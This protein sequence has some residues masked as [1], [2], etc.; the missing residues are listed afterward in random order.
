TAAHCTEGLVASRLY[1]I[2]AF[3]SFSSDATWD[4]IVGVAQK[5]EH[6]NY[7]QPVFAN[8][9]ISILTL[10]KSASSA[11]ARVFGG[12]D[13][14]AGKTSTVIGVGL[15]SGGG[16][17]PNILQ[18][19]NLQIVSNSVCANAWGSSSITPSML[20][21]GGTS[22][23][24]I[25]ACSGDSGGPLFVNHD[26]ERVQAGIVSWGHKDCAQPGFYDVYARTGAL[27]SFVRQHAPGA[28]I[29]V[30]LNFNIV[31]SLVPLLFDTD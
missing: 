30:D 22:S 3:H 20:C 5:A 21:A 26:G 17:T 18:K 31:P 4:K 8:N 25:G 16:T 15:L 28:A 6:P 10:K 19:V 23:G 9:D 11:K 27:I 2:P 1:V 13:Q 14:F 24:G 12:T 29:V 7:G